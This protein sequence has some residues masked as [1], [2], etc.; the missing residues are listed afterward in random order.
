MQANRHRIRRGGIALALLAAVVLAL[1][2][3]STSSAK[4]VAGGPPDTYVANWDAVGTQAFSAAALSPAE[5]HTIFAYVAIAVYDSVMAIKGG[6]EPFAVDVDAPANTSAEAAVAAAA[7]RVL[8]NYLPAQTGIVETAY[9]A[10]LSGIPDGVAK[11]NGV[12]VGTA[13]ADLLIVQRSDDGFRA[14]VGYT[15]P[16]PAGPG[17][18]V[19]TAAT[20]PIG[21]YL[22]RMRPFALRSADQFRPKGPPA[23]GS[24]KWADEY[25]EVKTIGSNAATSPRTADQTAGCTLLGRGPGAAGTWVVPQVRARSAARR[26]G[27]F[28]LHGDDVRDVRGRAHRVLRCEV[29]L[30][31]LAADHGD[32][33]GRHRRQLCDG[34]RPELD[35]T[36][37]RDSEPPGVPERA[38]VHHA[39]SRSR[40]RALPEQ[41][42]DRLHDPERDQ[43]ART[44]PDFATPDALAN[45]VSNARIWG[46]I[47]F[48]SA[49]EEGVKMSK[50]TADF[51]LAHNFRTSTN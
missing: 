35:A 33:R 29:P 36:A 5:G 6:H 50:R 12:T 2:G 22:G 17:D 15:P 16:N 47:H 28:A 19:P 9:A 30:R 32:P 11:T 21:S 48:R 7:R 37:T 34:R 1:S 18:W 51:I 20:P 41:S 43:P 8:E 40:D 38:L 49:V 44:R 26:G 25:N 23:L 3:A 24:K 39:G 31:A 27:R 45:E 10:S 4:P 13:V 46:G 42:A 14:N